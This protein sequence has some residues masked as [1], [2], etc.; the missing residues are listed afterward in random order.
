MSNPTLYA[1]SDR[2]RHDLTRRVSWTCQARLSHR[3]G[4]R[5]ALRACL[6]QGV[7]PSHLV[8]RVNERKV[9]ELPSLSSEKASACNWVTRDTQFD[10]VVKYVYIFFDF[11]NFV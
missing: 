5:Q 3:V 1:L 8:S 11:I 7:A 6:E 2:G 10:P 9:R 4:R